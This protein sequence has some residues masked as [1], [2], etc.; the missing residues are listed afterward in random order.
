MINIYLL[1]R[2]S[3]MILYCVQGFVL[4]R[5]ILAMS[6]NIIWKID[7][8]CSIGNPVLDFLEHIIGTFIVYKDC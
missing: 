7:T 5:R 3:N 8:F 4:S 2:M 6:S 1:P